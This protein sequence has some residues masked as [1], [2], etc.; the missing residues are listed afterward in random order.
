[1]KR[2]PDWTRNGQRT[3]QNQVQT[4]QVILP[5]VKKAAHTITID[6]FTANYLLT[7]AL[8]DHKTPAEII[9]EMVQQQIAT[10]MQNGLNTATV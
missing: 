3:L 9:S 5:G 2:Q 7:K 6:N 8:A 10:S 1:M 4:E